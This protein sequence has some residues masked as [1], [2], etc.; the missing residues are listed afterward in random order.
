MVVGRLIKVDFGRRKLWQV[1]D[2]LVDRYKWQH[3]D[4]LLFSH[5]VRSLVNPDPNLRATASS[6]LYHRWIK[7]IGI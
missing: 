5:F 2:I 6:A 3:E 7:E 1:E 4:A